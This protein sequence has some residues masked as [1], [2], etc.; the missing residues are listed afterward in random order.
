MPRVRAEDA[1]ARQGD[2]TG[3]GEHDPRARADLADEVFR[4]QVITDPVLLAGPEPFE[5]ADGVGVAFAGAVHLHPEAVSAGD[6]RRGV[7]AVPDARLVPVTPAGG[8]FGLRVYRLEI[9][10]RDDV[11]GLFAE[12]DRTPLVDGVEPAAARAGEERPHIVDRAAALERAGAGE[13]GRE[14]VMV[15]CAEVLQRDRELEFPEAVAFFRFRGSAAVPADV[16]FAVLAAPVIGERAVGVGDELEVVLPVAGGVQQDFDAGVGERFRVVAP[17]AFRGDLLHAGFLAFAGDDERVAFPTQGNGGVDVVDV[18]LE[19]AQPDLAGAVRDPEIHAALQLVEVFRG[20][21]DG[22]EQIG[23]DEPQTLQRAPVARGGGLRL[24]EEGFVLFD[25][26][27]R[28]DIAPDLA[29]GGDFG[30][31]PQIG[32]D[33]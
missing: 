28:V 25:F 9:A 32:H 7:E 13:V 4:L 6:E 21:G 1:A 29:D 18:A 19:G 33:G 11:R 2:R 10:V 20:L 24:V 5:T 23:A 15:D 3:L 12:L 17:G 14:A 8:L 16:A 30:D 27:G 26:G 31:R 22:P